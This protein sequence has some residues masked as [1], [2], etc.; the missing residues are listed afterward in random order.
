MPYKILI[1]GLSGSGKTTL[2]KKLLTLLNSVTWINADKVRNKYN[3]WDFSTEGRFRQCIRLK[4]LSEE[5]N[6]IYVI[7]DFIAPTNKLRDLYN[8]DYTI[9]MNTITNSI[10]NDTDKLFEK[11]INYNYKIDSLESL[12]FHAEDILLCLKKKEKE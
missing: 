10:Y 9:W 2:A 12:S 3:D 4:N 5:V 7:C 8:A 6:T 1:T 11:P